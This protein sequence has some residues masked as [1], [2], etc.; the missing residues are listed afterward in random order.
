MNTKP[1][2]STGAFP[3]ITVA[4]GQ[5]VDMPDGARGTQPH[6]TRA[7]HITFNNIDDL[8]AALIAHNVALPVNPTAA[9]RK[10][11]K[12][13]VP[14]WTLG[15]L[16]SGGSETRITGHTRNTQENEIFRRK[17][18]NIAP[19]NL[20]AIDLD[21]CGQAFYTFATV[22]GLLDDYSGVMY[23]TPSFTDEAPRVRI[24]L[25]T[26]QA[27]ETQDKNEIF[28][29][30]EHGFMQSIGAEYLADD[31]K[32]PHAWTFKGER[33]EF[34][35]CML[36]RNQVI[37]L[38][39]NNAEVFIFDGQ[40][41]NVDALPS[42]PEFVRIRRSANDANYTRPEGLSDAAAWLLDNGHAEIHNDKTLNVRCPWCEEHTDVSS[43]GELTNGT[44]FIMDA[45]RTK[46]KFKCSHTH[47]DVINADQSAFARVFGMPE[48]II[49]AAWGNV[50]RPE[51]FELLE[52]VTDK[53][54]GEL[55]AV[56]GKAPFLTHRAA[57]PRVP[58]FYD[59][60]G[61]T[62]NSYLDGIRQEVA[63]QSGC[64]LRMIP[65]R[66]RVDRNKDGKIV[67]FSHYP[68][69]DNFKWVI[70]QNH[71]VVSRNAL[72][73]QVECFNPR[74]GQQLA[75]SDSKTKALL[76][77]YLNATG[78]PEKLYQNYFDSVAEDS[79]YHPIKLML[80]GKKWD[81]VSRVQSVI[82]AVPVLPE[83][84]E[85]RNVL[86]K[87]FFVGAI[88]AL[89]DGRVSLKFAPVLFSVA[90]DWYKTAFWSRLF[91][92]CPGAFKEGVS[93]DPSNKDSVRKAVFS[94]ASELGELDQMTKKESGPLKAFIPLDVDEWRTENKA[95]YDHK[96]RQT[97]FPGTV[98]KASF[99]NDRTLSSR[100]PAI[101]LTGPID[102]ERVNRLLGWTFAKGKPALIDSNQLTQFWLEV[103]DMRTAGA[104]HVLDADSLA[105]MKRRNDR[106]VGNSSYR[107]ALTD[108]IVTWCE[109]QV[110]GASPFAGENLDAG[111][112]FT[113]TEAARY[114]D[115]PT[116]AV[117]QVGA[118][119]TEMYEE[120]MLHKKRAKK[121]MCYRV[122]VEVFNAPDSDC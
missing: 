34:D 51:D 52:R 118:A 79:A 1:K 85:Q 20:V 119:L 99:L 90:N 49:A 7:E 69:S 111:E 21:K 50:A 33:I 103:R 95:F 9:D 105:E 81:G 109:A 77:D 116:G 26:Q 82:D 12:N 83:D 74:T 40:P 92:I 19:C 22:G 89:D 63:D 110:S 27:I 14:F 30:F 80:H 28:T 15:G 68:H 32:A 42:L 43:T 35:P 120:G 65:P 8:A 106:Y 38:P 18:E 41:V 64:E 104:T 121:G 13:R 46:E 117:A 122:N 6:F 25:T 86:L 60:N 37:Y 11:V 97:V 31:P 101:E 54:G 39:A 112:W 59:W 102:I 93:I 47:G 73:W 88:A 98:N 56:D 3:P 23:Q 4:V 78:H 48:D 96:P 67:K 58:S 29:R 57:D 70:Y 17:T 87:T 72:T 84:V 62:G 113:T 36:K 91:S 10:D 24:L 71:T 5:Q 55:V 108:T 66:I 107:Q 61:N 76:L 2:H 94:W 53:T 45:E 75:A 44:V 16:K 114:I 115:A 100:F